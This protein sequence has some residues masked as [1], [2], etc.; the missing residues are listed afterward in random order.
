M[1]QSRH[2]RE[3]SYRVL[4]WKLPS[5]WP[6]SKRSHPKPATG[7]S[8]P[9]LHPITGGELLIMLEIGG[10]R[11]HALASFAVVDSVLVRESLRILRPHSLCGRSLARSQARM[12]SGYEGWVDLEVSKHPSW[13][14]TNGC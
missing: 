7:R 4:P 10:V 6:T 9:L 11:G 1:S 12:K 2:V 13:L 3:I 14:G 8:M 5:S